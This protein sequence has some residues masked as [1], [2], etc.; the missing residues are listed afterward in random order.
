VIVGFESRTHPVLVGSLVD[1]L[2]R[3][4][5]VPVAGRLAIDDDTVGPAHGASNS[6]QRVSAVL[7]RCG[8]D[9]DV[10]ALAGRRVLLVDDLVDTGWSMTVGARLLR[11]AG[12]EAVLPLALGSTS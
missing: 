2:S 7:R 12:A 1:G 8:L 9:A 5:G 10:A 4:L 6:A 3:H 11:L